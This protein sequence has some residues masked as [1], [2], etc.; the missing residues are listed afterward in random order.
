[1]VSEQGKKIVIL[2]HTGGIG[3][4]LAQQLL[5]RGEYVVGYSRSSTPSLELTDESSIEGVAEAAGFD[6]DWLINATGVLSDRPTLPER[7]LKTLSPETM[8]AQFAVN[9]IG[10]ALVLKHFF[11]RM[12]KESTS[13]MI[14]FSARVSSI[15][16]NRLGGWY[17]YRAS[18]AA[19]NQ[20]VKTAAIEINR[21]QPRFV[22]VAMHPGTVDTNLSKRFISS[23]STVQTPEQAAINLIKVFDSLTPQQSGRLLDYEGREIE[24]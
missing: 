1:M 13:L 3:Q 24:W 16:D 23:A 19:L 9:A 22:C 2:G 6:I 17:S 15:G 5:N 12:R 20:F 18:K 4:A 21:T 10:P 8:L 7:A 11:S 14:S